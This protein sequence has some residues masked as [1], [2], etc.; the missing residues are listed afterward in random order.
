LKVACL[1]L[2]WNSERFLAD[3]IGRLCK[4]T[5]PEDIIVVDNGSTDNTVETLT[6]KYPGV[7]L[8]RLPGNAGFAGGNNVGIK[9]AMRKGYDAVFLLNVDTIIDEDLIG[10]CTDALQK[11]SCMG[12][13]GPVVV[14]ADAP[15]VIQ[16]EGGRILASRSSFPYRNRGQRFRRRDELIDVGYVLGAAMMIRRELIE[17]IGYMDEDYYPAY[18]EE[19]DYCYRAHIAGY[20][21]AV[22]CGSAIRHIGKQSSG[23]RQ[24]AF[25][26]ISAHRFY[27]AI[28]HSGPFSFL[29][30]S[31]SIA[32]RIFY[33][34]FR[35]AL[36]SRL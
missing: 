35:A 6:R 30:A 2:T 32:T 21:C 15:G 20:R 11:H 8:Y 25:N 27:F 29:V 13:V 1:F 4:F 33:W 28:K 12:I 19:A 7:A 9:E 36:F 31:V 23:G 24:P 16:C 10:P 17:T 14:E 26:R 3:S 18:V 34:K 22:H 5:H